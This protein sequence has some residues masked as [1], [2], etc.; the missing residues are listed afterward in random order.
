M[1]SVFICVY[2]MFNTF[3]F[4][5]RMRKKNDIVLSTSCIQKPTHTQGL[6]F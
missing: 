3:R 5:K 2:D 4:S 6:M 1:N